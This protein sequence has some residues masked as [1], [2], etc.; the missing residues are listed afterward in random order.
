MQCTNKL[1]LSNKSADIYMLKTANKKI[2]STPVLLLSVV[3]LFTDMASEMLYP[4]M[5]LFLKNIGYSVLLIGIIEGVAEAVA[6]I[7][8]GYF[9]TLSDSR[10]KRLPFVQLG[11][12]LSALSKPLM[13]LF[14]SPA[15]VLTTR[16][17]D[18]IGKGVRTGARDALLSDEATP[19][20]KAT[21]FGFHRSMDTIGA[22]LGPFVA[23][24]YLYFYPANY[25]TLFLLA[26]APGIVAVVATFLLKEKKQ[27]NV[28][29]STSSSINFSFTKYWKTSSSSYK[30]LVITLL[31]IALVNSSDAFLLL[32][33]KQLGMQD[34]A[35]IGMYILY[36][37]VYALSAYPLGKLADNIGLKK[38]FIT[39]WA[40]FVLVYVGFAFNTNIWLA[41]L[42]MLLYGL[43]A[44]ATEGIAK[45]WISNI[46]TPTKTATALGTFSGYQSIASMLASILAGFIWYKFGATYCFLLTA[47][48]VAIVILCMLTKYFKI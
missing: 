47:T 15:W 11:Y 20:T 42:L 6:G 31:I 1:L 39:G 7:S 41:I 3:S 45:A 29:K 10:G 22:V 12:S 36:N 34:S 16:I 37:V 30:K 28:I 27:K 24:V 2:I 9:G 38:I 17:I 4:I 14:I 48:V 5:P 23:L 8:K 44:A 25:R 43:Y 35:I 46:V 18:R 19:Q 33:L 32:Q 26:F 13:A 40:L 21:V